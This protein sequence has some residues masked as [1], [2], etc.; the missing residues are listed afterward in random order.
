VPTKRS[1]KGSK[2]P[3]RAARAAEKVDYAAWKARIAADLATRRDVRPGVIPDRVWRRL[4]IR[5]MTP[6]DAADE[7]AGS[8]YNPR[9]A[10]DRLRL[11]R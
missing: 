10:A 5:G 11:A 9:A 2:A 3:T 4:Y 1:G 7:A 8:A 6:Q